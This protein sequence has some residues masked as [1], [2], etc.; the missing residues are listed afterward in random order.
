MHKLKSAIL[1]FLSGFI[2][3][4][5]AGASIE[6]A[7]LTNHFIASAEYR[8]GQSSKPAV[9]V[10][11]GF[12]STRNFLTVLNLTTAL[13]DSGYTVLAP[14]LSLG[15]NMRD[16]SLACE[17]IHMHTLADDLA[18]INFW[19]EWLVSHGHK[20]IVL[21][22]HSVGSLHGLLYTLEFKNPA[23]KKLIATSLVDMES[24]ISVAV[25]Q[26][27]IKK[28][29]ALLKRNDNTLASYQ[30]SYC[31]KYVAPPKAFLS[32]A[33]WT[34]QSVLH[35]LAKTSVPVEVILG[36]S[37]S[38]IGAAWPK[39]LRNAG[40]NLHVIPGANHFFSNEHE[41]DLLDSVMVALRSVH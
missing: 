33:S 15:V 37:D 22:G 31:K 4:T 20:T 35:A 16:V 24:V 27:Q 11:H 10:I 5:S 7:T 14:N 25:S 28:A 18:E 3:P 1:L 36:G 13:A 40:V 21:L 2:A 39:Q 30:L 23:V 8:P 9:L 41:F 17:A 26:A 32:Y 29:Q 19:V 38:R 12:L 34:G 6:T